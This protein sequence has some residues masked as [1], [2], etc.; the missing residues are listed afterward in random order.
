MRNALC[1][2]RVISDVPAAAIAIRPWN[3]ARPWGRGA[4]GATM[5]GRFR[6]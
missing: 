4:T 6:A 2:L 1:V 5:S 3:E